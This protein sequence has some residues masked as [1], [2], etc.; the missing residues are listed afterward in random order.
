[1]LTLPQLAFLPQRHLEV[2][3]RHDFIERRDHLFAHCTPAERQCLIQLAQWYGAQ[4][5]QVLKT[6][7][8]FCDSYRADFQHRYIPWMHARPSAMVR[9]RASV[10]RRICDIDQWLQTRLQRKMIAQLES[11]RQR[12]GDEVLMGVASYLRALPLE[13]GYDVQRALQEQLEQLAGKCASSKEVTPQ[14]RMDSLIRSIR[15][16]PNSD[17]SARLRKEVWPTLLAVMEQ[18]IPAGLHL[19]DTHWQS[20]E[21]PC[22]M[23]SLYLHEVP[24]LAH[25]LALAFH[26][27]RPAFASEMLCDSLM[28]LSFKLTKLEGSARDACEQVMDA[29]S[30]LL[31]DWLKTLP[32]EASDA[33]L[34]SITFLL[35]YGNPAEDYWATLPGAALEII[36]GLDHAK[37]RQYVR[38]MA[39]IPFYAQRGSSQEGEG[40]ALF[41]AYATRALAIPDD[42]TELSE[43][44]VYEICGALSILENKTMSYRNR[45]IDA[46]P[47][48]PLLR[49]VEVRLQQVL[50]RLTVQAPQTALPNIVGMALA[51]SNQVLVR[52]LHHI[53]R[54][55]FEQ[56]ARAFPE[57]GGKA[58]QRLIQSR[59]S[60]HSRDEMYLSH[61]CQETFDLLLPIL[62][63]IS[64]PDAAVARSGIGWDPRNEYM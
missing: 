14:Q 41:E 20:K 43:V 16:A 40:M 23:M 3:E 64:P 1:M 10:W 19:L 37:Q 21:S 26:P 45:R 22:I 63:R 60:S 6:P 46:N 54:T 29:S 13:L 2:K 59:S 11:M 9:I 31:A 36:K 51:L 48:H 53:L 15:A 38:L 35:A 25:R 12:C 50:E 28:S 30:R 17:D 62:D 5:H 55:Q 58:L 18:D 33:S 24:E 7:N 42:A 39:Q 34:R 32:S 49:V 4:R 52:K 56:R 57:S 44:D 61:I 27:H 47:S 8:I